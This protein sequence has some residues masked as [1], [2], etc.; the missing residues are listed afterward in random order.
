M[1]VHSKL[2]QEWKD[3]NSSIPTALR[4]RRLYNLQRSQRHC[5]AISAYA[6]ILSY[7]HPTMQTMQSEAIVRKCARCNL[8]QRT[9]EKCSRT[10]L[11]T[12]LKSTA[13]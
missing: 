5:R 1:D 12:Q 10:L 11:R 3:C 7:A 8:S 13:C 4:S 6:T 9:G 2:C